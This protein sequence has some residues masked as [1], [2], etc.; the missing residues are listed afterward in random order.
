[1][2]RYVI[3]R[4]LYVIPTI[5]GV[6]VLIFFLFT[7]AGEDPVL[8]VL[9]QNAT[10]EAIADLRALWGLDKPLWEQFLFFLRQIVTF[11]YGESFFTGETLSEVFASGALVSLNLTLPPFLLG[12]GVYVTLAMVIAY[13]RDTWLDR[14]A[15]AGTV[16]SM[17]VSYLVY[18][19]ALQYFLAF[20]LDLF[21]INLYDKADPV[22]YLALPWLILLLVSMGPD[23]RIYRTV[24]LDEIQANYV[25]TARAKGVSERGVLFVHVLKN[26]MIPILI[27]TVV[28]LP[29]LLLGTFLIERYFSLPGMGYLLITAVQD[30]DYPI[31]KGITMYIAIAYSLFNVLTD[32]LIAYV[33][34]RIQL[35]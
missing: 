20:Q 18:I 5:F 14:F 24:I 13:Y 22:P 31:L 21:P 25:R 29:F 26:A 35:K 16:M 10:P 8:R 27:Y 19:I 23:V 15:T 7:V 17:S 32:L 9:G 1:M 2:I 12:S 6:A 34:P 3:R 33:D 30:G 4:L 11:D 28:A